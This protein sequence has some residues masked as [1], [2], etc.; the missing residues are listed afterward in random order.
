MVCCAIG[1]GN[2]L[3]NVGPRPDGLIEE[4]HA[5]RLREMGAFLRKYGESIHATRGGPFIAPDEKKRTTDEERFRLAEGNWWGGS[6][7]KADAIYLHILRWP[8]ETIALPAIP[9]RILRH[10][11]LT[12]GR[13]EVR[14]SASGIEV[15][16]R[17]AHRHA[18]DT[19]VKLQLDGPAAGIPAIRPATTRS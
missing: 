8:A 12:G 5:A 1:D 4:S 18:L 16:V 19:I 9:R 14:Q 10:S 15:R 7:H 6:T 3:F 11:V 17:V 2:L 13:A